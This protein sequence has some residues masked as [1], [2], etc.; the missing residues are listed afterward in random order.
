MA[1][2]CPMAMTLNQQQQT[3]QL[4]SLI[5]EDCPR[6][7]NMSSQSIA[8]KC[9]NHQSLSLKGNTQVV[10]L[11]PL[12]D[13]LFTKSKPKLSI[14]ALKSPPPSLGSLQN[15]PLSQQ[16]EARPSTTPRHDVHE[17]LRHH[18]KATYLNKLL[19]DPKAPLKG[20]P[21][22]LCGSVLK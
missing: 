18:M 12:A 9:T 17:R 11:T 2:P 14:M 19:A 3:N 13:L 21:I 16:Q 20:L 6:L 10:D 1:L 5:L 7:T 4:Q 15:S 8:L 22:L